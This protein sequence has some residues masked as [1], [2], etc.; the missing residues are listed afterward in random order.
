M[1][2]R[3]FYS[4]QKM[5]L[6]FLMVV[7]L[8]SP[9][10]FLYSQASGKSR[11]PGR[12]V[13]HYVVSVDATGTFRGLI[14]DGEEQQ[15]QNYYKVIEYALNNSNVSGFKP[16]ED[17]DWVSLA[18]FHFPWKGKFEGHRYLYTSES[19]LLTKEFSQKGSMVTAFVKNHMPYFATRPASPIDLAEKSIVPFVNERIKANSTIR[20]RLKHRVGCFY[21]VSIHDDISS[22]AIVD[23]YSKYIEKF[24][25]KKDRMTFNRLT[26]D[27]IKHFTTRLVEQKKLFFDK[28]G[29]KIVKESIDRYHTPFFIKYFEIKPKPDKPLLESKN[30]VKLYRIAKNDKNGK[31]AVYWKGQTGAVLNNNTTAKKAWLEVS[32]SSK[33]WRPVK[34][35]GNQGIFFDL[36]GASPLIYIPKKSSGEKICD[37]LARFNRKIEFRAGLN[38]DAGQKE[39]SYPFDYRYYSDAKEIHYSA[40]EISGNDCV[41]PVYYEYREG[42]IQNQKPVSDTILSGILR[43]PNGLSAFLRKN[44]AYSEKNATGKKLFN[45]ISPTT[46]S[47]ISLERANQAKSRT[48]QR[49]WRILAIIIGAIIF[50]WVLREYLLKCR[51]RPVIEAIFEKAKKVTNRFDFSQET[52][53]KTTLAFIQVKNTREKLTKKRKQLPFTLHLELA[54]DYRVQPKE[55]NETGNVQNDA[56]SI[57]KLLQN[58][59]ETAISP[60]KVKER[61]LTFRVPSVKVDDRL[62]VVFDFNEIKDFDPGTKGIKKIEPQDI[63]ITLNLKKATLQ[64]E[65]HR[66]TLPVE[67]RD[68]EWK[69][70]H[71][72]RFI[73]ETQNVKE[74]I[75]VNPIL[76]KETQ[77]GYNVNYS[78]S[79]PVQKLFKIQLQNPCLRL[80]AQ[81]FAGTFKLQA[82][83]DNHTLDLENELHFWLQAEAVDTETASLDINVTRGQTQRVGLYTDFL[84]LGENSLKPR[85]FQLDISFNK[86]EF[87]TSLKLTVE[88]SNEKTEALVWLGDGNTSAL[89]KN[90]ENTNENHQL[91][92]PYPQDQDLLANEN[93]VNIKAKFSY[94]NDK[95][96]S[97]RANQHLFTMKLNNGCITGTGYYDWD[98]SNIKLHN[99][100]SAE[101]KHEDENQVISLEPRNNSGCIED[102]AEAEE[103]LNFML[104]AEAVLFKKFMLSLKVTF[105]LRIDFFPDGYGNNNRQEKMIHFEISVPHYHDVERNYLV[106]DYGTSAIAIKKIKYDLLGDNYEEIHGLLKLKSPDGHMP[107]RDSL[108]P[109]IINLNDGQLLE[110]EEFISLPAERDIMMT[111]PGTVVNA[112]KLQIISG[113]P[114]I[115]IPKDFKY[116]IHAGQTEQEVTDRAIEL[117]ALLKSAYRKLKNVYIEPE[118]SDYKRLIITCP[119]IY[120]QSHK[121]F[122][123]NLL[124]DIFANY[125][126]GRYEKNFQLVSESD[127]VLYYYLKKKAQG[128]IIT[129]TER[130][131][132]VDIGGG[133]LDITLAE[134]LWE[135]NKNY[136]T[137]VEIIIRDGV[138][139]AGEVLDKAIALQTHDLINRFELQQEKNSQK[140]DKTILPVVTKKDASDPYHREILENNEKDNT[141][142]AKMQPL[143]E[144]EYGDYNAVGAETKQQDN[145][146]LEYK[147]RIVAQD[148]HQKENQ[149]G[150]DETTTKQNYTNRQGMMS[151]FKYTYIL[152]FKKQMAQKKDADTVKLCLGKN[153]LSSGLCVFWNLGD[154]TEKL[155]IENVIYDCRIRSDADGLNYLY[156]KKGDWLKLP[157]IKRFKA[158]FYQK[159][160]LFRQQKEVKDVGDLTV[161]LSGRTSLWPDIPGVIRKVFNKDDADIWGNDTHTRS[162]ELKR[163]VIE[164]AAQKVISWPQVKYSEPEYIGEPAIHYR[165]KPGKWIKRILKTGETAKI[166]LGN[167]PFFRLG[168]K[169]TLDFVS[170]LSCNHMVREH[171]CLKV[172][173]IELKIE[174]RSDGKVVSYDFF[175]RSDKQDGEF[176]KVIM[177]GRTDGSAL[178]L[179][180]TNWPIPDSWLPEVKSSEFNEYT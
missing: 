48:Q 120:N 49:I 65:N 159:L 79:C 33:L 104:N 4:V 151:D 117:E 39:Y 83:E 12:T 3:R 99:N 88:P 92:F 26:D 138:Q 172:F 34:D 113:T 1:M 173:E 57:I 132:I 73:P 2:N 124:H 78:T 170:F 18:F 157:Y 175:I 109:S 130:V 122:L 53:E 10:D 156:L 118:V 106:V 103:A 42:E 108:L 179:K 160:D 38:I 139:F 167:S 81:P 35:S 94:E 70:E 116:Y 85:N 58:N 55:G 145:L 128:S 15:T 177:D 5:V 158:L 30:N 56:T 87:T 27:F 125:R 80:F 44:P 60:Q 75:T 47:A 143:P 147:N 16:L 174:A 148:D 24:K 17:E 36:A 136:P 178:N 76:A 119:N 20:A 129:E 133:T 86:G 23:S 112:L 126:L 37:D 31:A 50:L 155:N 84:R 32:T 171:Y 165:E 45:E 93:P 91:V 74:N 95:P 54:Y 64:F 90:I 149:S 61:T 72:V 46:V 127:A 21:L 141:A 163:A 51:R 150:E 9:N 19:L 102:T 6:L 123:E 176:R 146:P 82:S 11:Q 67:K 71:T 154:I 7:A 168:I 152:D 13:G 28:S 107:S 140:K 110:S 134:V 153:N 166:D 25:N 101:L 100:E 131:I 111:K 169:T 89:Y 41:I 114:A 77:N 97:N 98:I 137:E 121:A 142:P 115:S 96:I 164:G 52:L 62:T 29:N 144:T 105:T 68:D 63:K 161:I 40:T 43:D 14:G 162:L 180:G 8:A 59:S 135:E 69:Q 66:K 22:G